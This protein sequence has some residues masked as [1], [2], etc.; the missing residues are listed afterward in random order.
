MGMD[1]NVIGFGPLTKEILETDALDYPKSHYEGIP[2][3]TMITASFFS[4]AT[5]SLSRELATALGIDN[6]FDFAKHQIVSSIKNSFWKDG[7]HASIDYTDRTARALYKVA[8]NGKEPE[9]AEDEVRCFYLCLSAGWTFFY[10]PN[11]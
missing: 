2:F 9:E 6:P 1:A 3:G 4:C 8:L 10:Q 11:Y 5:S 7:L